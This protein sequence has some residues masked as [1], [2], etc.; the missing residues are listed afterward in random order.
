M[1]S[2]SCRAWIIRGSFLPDEIIHEAKLADSGKNIGDKRIWH[3]R[4]DIERQFHQRRPLSVIIT[5]GFL[6]H[7]RGGIGLDNC[8]AGNEPIVET[9][10]FFI[11]GEKISRDHAGIIQIAIFQKQAGNVSIKGITRPPIT[12]YGFSGKIFQNFFAVNDFPGLALLIKLH[13]SI[14]WVRE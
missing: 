2:K 14:Q 11:Q 3:Q 8:F 13:N 1:N 10:D 7:Q 9:K 6:F 12:D 4:Q 5:Y